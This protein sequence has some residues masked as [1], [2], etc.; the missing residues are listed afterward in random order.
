MSNNNLTIP[1][2]AR[3]DNH[4]NKFF[5]GKLESPISI[6]CK[7]GVTF[8]IFTSEAGTEELQIAN[9]DKK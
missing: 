8:I 3:T 5:V 2:H 6:N 1:L 9:M 4:G 7:E